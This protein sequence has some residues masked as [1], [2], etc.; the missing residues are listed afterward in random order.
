MIFVTVGAQMPFDR[1]VRTVD[2]WAAG[3]PEHHVLAQIGD[4]ASPPSAMH[5]THRLDAATFRRCLFE[6]DL[7]VTHAGMGT[8]LT[9]LE[10]GK[11]TIVMPRR[12]QLRETRNDHQLATAESLLADERI[13]VAWDER[14]LLEKLDHMAD[15]APPPPVPS[16]ASADLLDALRQFIRD[17]EVRPTVASTRDIVERP[18]SARM[19]HL[20]PP[21]T[22]PL[23]AP[24]RLR[25]RWAA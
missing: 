4:G 13:A 25:P 12:G 16:H 22:A 24:W 5:W 19:D 14:E 20:N 10:L 2:A 15:V 18:A 21:P 11:P 6:A 9:A 8:I 1:L 7:V 17:G 3:H 23:H